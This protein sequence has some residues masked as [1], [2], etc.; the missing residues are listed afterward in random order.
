MSKYFNRGYNEVQKKLQKG[1][2]YTMSCY[3]CDYF[4]QAS[5][6]KEEVCQNNDVLKYDMVLTNNNIYCSKWKMSYREIKNP[7][8]KGLFKKGGK[9][10][11]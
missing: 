2:K 11:D 10:N 7:S 9:R 8:V 1:S 5:G 6:D 3:N 4:Y